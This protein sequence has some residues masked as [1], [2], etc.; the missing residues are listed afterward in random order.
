[1]PKALHDIAE[2]LELP[3]LTTRVV[4]GLTGSMP[5]VLSVGNLTSNSARQPRPATMFDPMILQLSPSRHWVVPR[6]RTTRARALGPPTAHC[7]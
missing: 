6:F 5:G 1:V 7:T 2:P 4:P 3:Q